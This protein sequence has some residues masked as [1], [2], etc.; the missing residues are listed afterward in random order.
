M[1]LSFLLLWWYPQPSPDSGL[2]SFFS[3]P[4]HCQVCTSLE[5]FAFLLPLFCFFVFPMARSF[6]SLKFQLKISSL[7]WLFPATFPKVVPETLTQSVSIILFPILLSYLFPGILPFDILV[8]FLFTVYFPSNLT[9]M[10]HE[11]RNISCSL[12]LLHLQR[13]NRH[14]I[15]TEWMNE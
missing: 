5:A 15:F 3:G 14:F 1:L 2:S 11:N 8:S 10:F 13:K 4:Y 7:L 12:H 6:S 9:Y